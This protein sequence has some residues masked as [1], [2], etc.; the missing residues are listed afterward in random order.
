MIVN[1]QATMR[2]NERVALIETMGR[3]G[4]DIALYSAI[5]SESDIVLVPEDPKKDT[6]V[7][8]MI[9]DEIDRGNQSPIVILA[10]KQFDLDKLRQKV[11][12]TTNK[13]CRA[14]ILGYMQRG[15]GPNMADRTLAIRYGATAIS[16]ISNGVFNVALGVDDDMIITTPIQNAVRMKSNFRRDL[17]DLFRQLHQIKR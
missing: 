9:L 11:E 17:Y 5:A 1:I 16:L 10:E 12:K 8:E 6:T 2:A 15:G 4:G 13:E 14:V 7:V 3:D